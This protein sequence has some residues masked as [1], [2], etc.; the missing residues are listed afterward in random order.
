MGW[1]CKL[2][3]TC[4]GSPP[5][6]TTTTTTT[7]PGMV[8]T[9]APGLNRGVKDKHCRK[10]ATGYEQWPC[11]EDHLCICT[12]SLIGA[13]AGRKAHGREHHFLG[14]IQQSDDV[15]KGAFD[16]EASSGLSTEEL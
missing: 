16:I 11:N 1:P 14:L 13:A 12:P 8:C 15:Q 10:C 5:Q 7:A 6:E 2:L 9:A 3:C 4:T